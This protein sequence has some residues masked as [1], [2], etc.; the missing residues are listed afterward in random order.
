MQSV[1]YKI[2]AAVPIT[3]TLGE[4][5]EKTQATV[6]GDAATTISGV[7]AITHAKQ[8]EIT[9][10]DNKKFRRL[11]RTCN[12]SAVI[13][14]VQEAQDCPL[15]ALI[16]SDPK[17]VYAQVAQLLYPFPKRAP[18]H[19]PSAV[20]GENTNIHSDVIIGPH[21]VIGNNVTIE[22]NVVIE[23]GCYIG[24]GCHIGQGTQLY[25]R[26]TVYHG[27]RIGNQCVVHAG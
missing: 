9:F 7:G 12:A 14:G 21:C 13:I 23:A 20:I 26:V 5:A 24:D 4:L 17:L 10:L 3:L 18:M 2:N 1:E 19:H 25:P 6:Q 27:C 8:G 15:P 16:C 22:A 11:L